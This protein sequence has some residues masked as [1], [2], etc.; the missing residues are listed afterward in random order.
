M[1]RVGTTVYICVRNPVGIGR[2]LSPPDPVARLLRLVEGRH[3]R[4][5]EYLLVFQ[6]LEG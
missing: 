1:H 4:G 3:S 6:L 2:V 5:P